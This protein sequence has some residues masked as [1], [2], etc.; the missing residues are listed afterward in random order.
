MPRAET[1]TE[2]TLALSG[3]TSTE[4]KQKPKAREVDASMTDYV[5]L[6]AQAEATE[7]R[8]QIRGVFSARSAEQAI[9]EAVRAEHSPTG[10]NP[11]EDEQ[12]ANAVAGLVF[13][14]IPHRSWKPTRMKVERVVSLRLSEE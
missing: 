1:T 7:R 6:D 2:G 13:V 4:K 3:E 12:R 5:V 8:W 11:E 9:R 14:A 10:K